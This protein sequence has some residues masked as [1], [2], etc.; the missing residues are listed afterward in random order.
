M[1]DEARPSRRSGTIA[2]PTPTSPAM[3]N[4]FIGRPIFATVLALLML[5]VGGSCLFGLPLSLYPK[6]VPPQVQVTPTFTGAD[7]QTVADTVATPIEQQV[8]GVKGQ[9]YFSSD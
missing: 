5:L 9:I 4:F 1:V 6:I 7:A 2:S 8:N 3:V